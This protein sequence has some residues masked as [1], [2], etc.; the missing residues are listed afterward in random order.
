M[1]IMVMFGGRIKHDGDDDQE[2]GCCL[3]SLSFGL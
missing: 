1:F 2:N 3:L